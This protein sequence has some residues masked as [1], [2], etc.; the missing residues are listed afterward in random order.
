MLI[1][2][3][4]L[5]FQDFV[6]KLFSLV[7]AILIWLT[8]FFAIQK[9]VTPLPGAP[10]HNARVRFFNLPIA[11]VATAQDV[12]AFRVEPSDVEITLE[13]DA[14]LIEKLQKRDI[15]VM[16]D[17]SGIESPTNFHKR[18]EVSTPAGV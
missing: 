9:E 17:L 10:S 7:L 4:D 14:N 1:F 2:L 16:V 18:I 15:R 5:I 3:R 13:G 6:L 12:G 11:V 8:I